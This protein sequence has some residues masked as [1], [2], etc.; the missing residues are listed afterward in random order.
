MLGRIYRCCL[1]LLLASSLAWAQASPAVDPVHPRLDLRALYPALAERAGAWIEKYGL[2]VWHETATDKAGERTVVLQDPNG[3]RLFAALVRA[4]GRAAIERTADIDLVANKAT[5][6]MV[7]QALT[8]AGRPKLHALRPVVEWKARD[9]VAVTW[10]VE[11]ERPGEIEMLLF[12][13]GALKPG[14]AVKFALPVA[15]LSAAPAPGDALAE[16]E[17]HHPKMFQA[18]ALAW[19]AGATTTAARVQRVYEG[20]RSTYRYDATIFEIGQFTWSDLLVRD[21]NHRGGVCD[22]WSVVG[23]TYLRALGIPARLKF[24]VWTEAGTPAAHAVL[25]YQ[26]GAAWKHFDPLWEAVADPAVYRRKGATGVTVMDAD[27][28]LD[29]RS[30][31]DSWGHADPTGDY[32][33]NPYGDF[34][35]APAFPGDARPGYSR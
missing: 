13:G 24:L 3:D 17:L 28:P 23:I 33:L 19:T 29:R 7:F 10:E 27:S 16:N 32:K 35:L 14:G 30:T 5:R 4:G 18:E 6:R 15:T 11:V 9:Q 22:E 26:D 34:I 25:E 20:I 31:A 8:G 12:D 21:V 2:V 1:L